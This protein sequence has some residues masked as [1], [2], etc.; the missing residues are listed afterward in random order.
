MFIFDTHVHSCL[1]W[2]EPVGSLL[3]Q[4]DANSVSR[5]LLVAIHGDFDSSYMF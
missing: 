2:Y 1:K 3:Y 5:A 4:M